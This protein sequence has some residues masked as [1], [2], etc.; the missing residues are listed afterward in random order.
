VA[1]FAAIGKEFLALDPPRQLL[2]LASAARR[3]DREGAQ[4]QNCSGVIK[5]FRTQMF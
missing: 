3:A 4:T 1:A 5:N 2:S